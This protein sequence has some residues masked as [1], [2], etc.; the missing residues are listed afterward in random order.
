MALNRRF[1]SSRFGE[2]NE[3]TVMITLIREVFVGVD[4]KRGS[5]AFVIILF[6]E[7]CGSLSF[8]AL[9]TTLTTVRDQKEIFSGGLPKR[10][11]KRLGKISFVWDFNGEAIGTPAQLS[12]LYS[13][14]NV[15]PNK[16]VSLRKAGLWI[17][18][19][20]TFG[21]QKF[22]SEVPDDVLL[23][24]FSLPG[25]GNTADDIRVYLNNRDIVTNP[26]DLDNILAEC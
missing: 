4:T 1:K 10:D 3:R 21:S 5:Q 19:G 24:L 20:F 18:R 23:Y 15:R 7:C 9:G 26:D 25:S 22:F 17:D 16:A 14:R 8:S 11:I 2:T 13:Q 12:Y 6:D